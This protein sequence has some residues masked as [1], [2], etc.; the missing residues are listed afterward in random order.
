MAIELNTRTKII[1]GVAVLALAGA[2]AWFFYFQDEP[3]PP[4]PQAD[5]KPA[6]DASKA[7]GAPKPAAD[8]AKAADAPKAAATESKPAAA[9]PA[10]KPIPGNPDLLIAE[11]IETSGLKTYFQTFAREAM[12]KA[13]AGSAAGQPGL[14]AA[15]AKQVIDMVERVFD[16][17]K[18]SS[19]LAPKLKSGFNAERMVRYLELLRQSISLKMTSQELRN[20][21]QEAIKEHS[22]KLAKE[23]LSAE[24]GVVS[25]LQRSQAPTSS[26]GLLSSTCEFGTSK[27]TPRESASSSNRFL[28]IYQSERCRAGLR[29]A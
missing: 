4:P 23:P 17:S 12:L 14:S 13:A 2:G 1:A 29:S 22:D 28:P 19:E 10:P 7:V 3:P 11:V 20:V 9:K 5:A 15:E 26:D 18:I 24:R 8:A 16:S 27:E 21:P 25:R 6:A